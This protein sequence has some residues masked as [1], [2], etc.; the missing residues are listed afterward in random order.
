MPECPLPVSLCLGYL[1][2]TQAFVVLGA[3]VSLVLLV[4]AVATLRENLIA[5][6]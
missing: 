4:S 1:S 3:F 6:P 5:V 2:S